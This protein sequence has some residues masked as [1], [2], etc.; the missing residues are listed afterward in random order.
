MTIAEFINTL[1]PNLVYLILAFS[2]WLGV[3]AV[4]IPGTGVAELAALVMLGVSILLMV[5]LPINW[6]AVIALVM[7][8]SAFKIVPF[9]SRKYAPIAYAGIGLQVVGALF[10]FTDG[11]QVSPFLILFIAA[12]PF[13]YYQYFLLPMMDK[14]KDLYTAHRDELVVGAIGR[15]MKD[16]DPVGTINVNSELWTAYSEVYVEAGHDVIVVAKEGLRLEVEPIKEKRH[17]L[18]GNHEKLLES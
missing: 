13:V 5:Q 16:L 2:L 12:V 18:N 9:I 14:M 1:D 8:I 11:R 7:G 4:Y 10:M 17:S 15:V 3:T 6:I